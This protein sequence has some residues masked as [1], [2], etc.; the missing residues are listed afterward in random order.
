MKLNR[1]WTAAGLLG[2]V[3]L[4]R[5]C[6][7][8]AGE[9]VRIQTARFYLKGV[10]ILRDLF[11]YQ[12]GILACVVVLVFG[13]I[14]IQG[15]LVFLIPWEPGIR[16]A[17][18]LI[19]GGADSSIALAFLLYFASSKRWLRQAAKYNECLEELTMERR[20]K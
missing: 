2:A 10:G 20:T 11:L 4:A 14:L 17:V 5:E 7:K 18:V 12:I 13:F 15:G 1:G 9:L 3:S 16:L 8:N 6:K 19:M